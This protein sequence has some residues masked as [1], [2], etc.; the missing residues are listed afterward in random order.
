MRY[1]L[2]TS[3]PVRGRYYVRRSQFSLSLIAASHRYMYLTCF[4][5]DCNVLCEITG[6]YFAVTLLCNTASIRLH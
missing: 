4:D 2:L 1:T 5:R 3:L 6:L